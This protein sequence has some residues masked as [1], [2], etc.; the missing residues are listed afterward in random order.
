VLLLGTLS[1]SG[2]SSVSS[3]RPALPDS[4]FTRV[5]VETHLMTA[6]SRLETAFPPSLSDSILQRYNVDRDAV[7]ATLR[8]YSERPDEFASLYTAVVDTLNAIRQRRSRSTPVSPDTTT[9][10]ERTR[11]QD[12]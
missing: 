5:L 4:T 3:E 6:R 12:E 9:S 11:R 10:G 7:D 2:C 1:L 8:Y